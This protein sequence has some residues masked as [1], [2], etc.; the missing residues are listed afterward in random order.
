MISDYQIR[1]RHAILKLV[2]GTKKE[3]D[4][5]FDNINNLLITSTILMVFSC[6]MEVLMYLLFNKK[7]ED[8]TNKSTYIDKNIFNLNLQF[9]P[10]KE[11]VAEPEEENA[12][13]SLD[14]A[15]KPVLMKEPSVEMWR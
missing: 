15:M 12:N 3:E 10:R 8:N 5:S 9:H 1:S 13:G 14:N 7:V 2:S 11:I 6:I 4:K